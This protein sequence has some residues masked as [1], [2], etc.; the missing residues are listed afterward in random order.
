MRL[1]GVLC[2]IA[3]IAFVV[4]L[5]WTGRSERSAAVWTTYNKAQVLLAGVVAIVLGVLLLLGGVN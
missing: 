3:G 1:V 4:G 5:R 2:I